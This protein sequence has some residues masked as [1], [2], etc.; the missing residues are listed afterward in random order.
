MLK[1]LL[2]SKAGVRGSVEPQAPPSAMARS[3]RNGK[4][5]HAGGR[6]ERPAPRGPW[7]KRPHAGVGGRQ[8]RRGAGQWSP[9]RGGWWSRAAA[10]ELA[11]RPAAPLPV[12]ARG[13]G[14]QTSTRRPSLDGKGEMRLT[15]TMAR[16][17][18]TERSPDTGCH[19]AEPWQPQAGRKAATHRGAHS[20]DPT[21]T[22]RPGERDPVAGRRRVVP[23]VEEQGLGRGC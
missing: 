9:H 12:Q 16:H 23:G 11:T 4:A 2:A 5:H 20:G 3:A 8:R 7:E 15:S 21:H 22:G 10:G 1:K 19:V 13:T 14:G 6:L 17:V 18:A